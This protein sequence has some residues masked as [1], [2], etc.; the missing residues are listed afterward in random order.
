MDG[1]VYYLIS[2][3]IQYNYMKKIILSIALT[4]G[5][6]ASSYAGDG[7]GD[8][9]TSLNGNG[10]G[11]F[12]GTFTDTGGTASVHPWYTFDANAGDTV[13]ITLNSDVDTIL[14][15][16][17]VLDNSA[18]VGDVNGVD[19]SFS[20]SNGGTMA[21]TLNFIAP[22]TGQY[23][24]QVDSFFGAATVNYTL[25]V[26]GSSGPIIPAVPTPTLQQWALILLI[27]LLMV[28]V[29]PKLSRRLK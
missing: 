13:T 15:V 10:D 7:P 3:Q 6:V 17:D 20:D 19:Y 23:V 11:T 5:L 16:F 29:A 18:Q 24:I 14:W 21:N 4:F 25:I 1:V 22:S 8:N 26:S 27:A 2:L 9:I 28:V 12:T